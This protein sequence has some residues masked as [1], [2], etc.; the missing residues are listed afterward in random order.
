MSQLD[1]RIPLQVP[2]VLAQ[3]A[4]ISGMSAVDQST[5]NN[6]AT[7]FNNDMA[8]PLRRNALAQQVEEDVEALTDG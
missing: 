6:L 1:T 8:A 3:Q 7:Q 2:N 5:R 4:Q